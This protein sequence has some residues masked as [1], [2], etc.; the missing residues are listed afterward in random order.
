METSHQLQTLIEAV[1]EV[2]GYS[3]LTKA[4]F[5]E[6][7]DSRK[8]VVLAAVNLIYRH[9]RMSSILTPGCLEIGEAINQRHDTVIYLHKSAID[10]M[11]FE[12][13]FKRLYE[14]VLNN[15]NMRIH[16]LYLSAPVPLDYIG[17]QPPKPTSYSWWMDDGMIETQCKYLA[18]QDV[19]VRL[20]SLL[21]NL[22]NSETV[23]EYCFWQK[24]QSRLNQY[25][26]GNIL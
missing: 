22:D 5:K 8:L 13:V 9:K 16:A 6:Y 1:S 19:S 2:T 24:V 21:H 11:C 4:R 25:S 17:A 20:K 12:S 26:D 7:V 14:Q 15:Y 18:K 23:G 3:P 10:H